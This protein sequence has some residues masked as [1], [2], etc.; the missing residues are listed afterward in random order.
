MS[1]FEL[2]SAGIDVAP[3]L[4]QLE[5]H[6]ELWN[7]HG[8]R[9][10]TDSPH[11]GIDDIWVRYRP[12]DELTGPDKFD[13]P[14]FAGFYPAWHVLTELQPIVFDLMAKARATYLGGILITHIPPMKMV[15]PH[16]DHGW[17]PSHHNLK[18]YVPIKSNPFCINYCGG[19]AVAMKA[20]EAWSFDNQIEHKVVNSGET[21]RY[22][23]IICLRTL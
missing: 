17:H 10:R 15:K 19:E 8:G 7:Q 4:S 21:D 6:P 5:D 11:Y 22:T 16:A 2:I 9:T 3:L 23:A 20:G 14:H 12:H 1:A 13:E 18:I